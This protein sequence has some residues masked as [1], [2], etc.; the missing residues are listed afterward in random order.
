MHLKRSLVWGILLVTGWTAATCVAS[1]GDPPKAEVELLAGQTA[2]VPG[3]SIPL[4]IQFQI[5][6]QWHLYW[7]NPGE[8][9]LEPT[10][11]WHLPEGFQIGPLRWPAP[12]RYVDAEIDAHSYILEGRPTLLTELSAPPNARPGETISIGV[13]ANW[14]ACKNVCVIE[15]KSLALK[16]PVVADAAGAEPA[17]EVI[18]RSARRAIPAPADQAKY[19]ESLTAQASVDKV[20][21]G[22]KFEVHVVVEVKAGHHLN[23]HQ[24]L[25]PG[26]RRT[27]LFPHTSDG[28][29]IGRPRF[30]VGHLEQLPTGERLSVYRGKTTITI[31]VQADG[32]LSATEL[33]VSGVLTYQACDDVAQVCFP[34]MAAEWS[35][36]LPVAK[37]GETVHV[38]EATQPANDQASASA[39]PGHSEAA[40]G[41]GPS[42]DPPSPVASAGGTGFIG[43]L[44]NLLL[45]MGVVGLLVLAFLGGLLMNVMPCVLPVISIKVLS[46]VQQAKES[47]LRIMT[48]GLA[49]SAGIVVS[50]LVFGLLIMGLLAGLGLEMQ[51]GGLF[52]EPIVVIGLAALLTAMALSLF[53]VFT[54]SPPR[55]IL[56]LSG[57][58]RQEGHLNAF[59]T[60][61]LATVLGTACT[62]PLVSP[63]VAVAANQPALIGML[64]FLAMGL[65]MAAPYV[66]L[67]ARPAWVRFIPR[68]GPWM[69]T[70]E[71]VMAF[72]LLAT[73]AFLLSIV[74]SQLGG[75]G[76]FWT[77]VFLLFVAAA[78]W[79]YGKAEAGTKPAR[80]AIAYAGTV[81]L[82]VGGW[83]FSFVLMAPLHEL[84]ARQLAARRAA[85]VPVQLA[86]PDEN[87]IPWVPYTRER[88]RELVRSGR[89][90]FIDYTADWCINCKVNE[91]LF[92]N[93]P[94]VRQAMR[95]L[96]V[97]PIKADN[98]LE[99]PEIEAD[100]KRF[101]RSG[102]PMY[103]I[104][105]ANQWDQPIL[106]NEILTQ[107]AVLEGLQKAGPSL[108]PEMRVAASEG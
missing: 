73:A 46:F 7:R 81:L 99:D 85:N 34:A 58:L 97:V 8:G 95:Q 82:F 54:L 31:P 5:A 47:R 53:G 6:P 101:N 30:P 63:A 108:E 77:L 49:F 76:A 57:N 50:F 69:K 61:L 72:L 43:W 41:E 70:F 51:W 24:P 37:P 19:L 18:F 13:D 98:T 52:Q 104:I 105:P 103:V 32:E 36:T 65:G 106:L 48:L 23:S 78:M 40:G 55:F 28:L 26:L 60:G 91:K 86:W 80:Q 45:S 102:V 59:G 38:V 16:L 56:Q 90:V 27:D 4:A 29:Q 84:E 62:A 15:K 93:T 67:A 107:G 17:N 25:Q 96:G 89:T 100:L 75:E 11:K 79:S 1:S 88:A 33:M 94:A 74:L 42:S 22:A 35:A 14:M 10:F 20:S 39:E 71:E 44:M 2:I 68:P 83:W 21:P 64:T 66:L 12:T 87:E 9:G 3:Q 92:I